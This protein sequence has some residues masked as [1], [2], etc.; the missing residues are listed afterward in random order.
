MTEM[1]LKIN[2][3]NKDYSV[4]HARTFVSLEENVGRSLLHLYTKISFS[5][6]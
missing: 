6:L 2:G 1:V 3:E 5:K 4:N